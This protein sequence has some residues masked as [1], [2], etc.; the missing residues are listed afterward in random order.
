MQLID[1]IRTCT[2]VLIG[3]VLASGLSAVALGAGHRADHVAIARAAVEAPAHD[4]LLAAS[5]VNPTPAGPVVDPAPVPTP[6]VEAPDEQVPPTA[7]PTAPSAAAP[8]PSTPPRPA[9]T[10]TAPATTAPP[11]PP[12]DREPA[13]TRATREP[14]CEANMV[15]FMN[16]TRADHG[17]AP[18]TA[19]AGIQWIPVHWSDT[20][21]ANQRLEHN[22]D[23]AERIFTAR[24]QATSASE[25]V[26]RTTGSDRSVFDGFMDSPPHR[27]RILDAA[28]THT[29]VGCVRDAGGQLW[30][31]V[32][33]WG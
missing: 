13:E 11:A 19:D 20:M 33:F 17:L 32:N 31:T 24:P 7:L 28:S 30:V 10:T 25:N 21:A 6:V 15:R 14:S 2:A 8:P 1:R 26:G 9:P 16:A 4:E 18:L 23:F 12:S 5:A 3:F 29:T 27:E 22:P